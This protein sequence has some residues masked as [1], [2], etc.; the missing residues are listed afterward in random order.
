MSPNSLESWMLYYVAVVKH[1]HHN[2]FRQRR[3][4]ISDL[5]CSRGDPDSKINVNSRRVQIR[6]S[7]TQQID[8]PQYYA[9]RTIHP[10]VQPDL[11]KRCPYY[12]RILMKNQKIEKLSMRR[13]LY[14]HWHVPMTLVVDSHSSDSHY[15]ENVTSQH[16]AGSSEILEIRDA[17]VRIKFREAYF[18]HL[19]MASP[20]IPERNSRET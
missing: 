13:G 12:Q 18:P 8:I 4:K 14:L 20:K 10:R 11:N 19:A 3:R 7:V 1:Y 9:R 5:S 6:I 16:S 17:A 2:Q 15:F